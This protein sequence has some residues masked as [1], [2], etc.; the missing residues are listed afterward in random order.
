M[1]KCEGELLSLRI[2][3]I[4]NAIIGDESE[5]LVLRP[6]VFVCDAAP[7]G[8]ETIHLQGCLV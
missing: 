7:L 8:A 5:L 2:Y 4:W 1:R 6:R 3:S